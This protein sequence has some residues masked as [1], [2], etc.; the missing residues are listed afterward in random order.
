MPLLIDEDYEYLTEIGHTYEE[1]PECR[2]FV[3]RAFVLP[4]GTY[5]TNGVPTV[6]VDVLIEIPSNYN[7]SGPDMFWVSPYLTLADGSE[8]PAANRGADP[9]SF[10]GVTFERW[11]RHWGH[12]A[13]RPGLDSIETLID[14]LTWAFAHPDPRST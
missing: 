9:R 8:I 7:L 11:S 1:D 12:L 10:N 3:V 6:E 5:S 2:R 13:W 4:E 14:R